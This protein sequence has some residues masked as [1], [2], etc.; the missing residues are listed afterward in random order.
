VPA[1]PRFASRGLFVSG[2]GVYL[3]NVCAS[4]FIDVLHGGTIN[5]F[6]ACKAEICLVYGGNPRLRARAW[7]SSSI[8]PASSLSTLVQLCV[9]HH[10]PRVLI[11]NGLYAQV[12]IDH[13]Y[14]SKVACWV[15]T[16]PISRRRFEQLQKCQAILNN[17]KS[18][19]PFSTMPK[20]RGLIKQIPN[21]RFWK[22][23]S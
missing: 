1:S 2:V 8:S 23:N 3:K 22:K 13:Q 15:T 10:H 4:R 12:A 19:M 11:Q 6:S 16:M 20:V 14:I 9:L 7:L 5:R 21:S 17:S 18:A